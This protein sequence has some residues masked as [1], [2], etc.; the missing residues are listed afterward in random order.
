MLADWLFANV[1]ANAWVRLLAGL[2]ILLASG[3]LLGHIFER[4]LGQPSLVGEV[5]A[6]MLLAVLGFGSDASGIRSVVAPAV[7]NQISLLAN[8][9][10]LFFM[11]VVG[12]EFDLS[13]LT[14]KSR[15]ALVIS[16]VSIL[17]PLSLALL[18]SPWLY[19][20]YGA[21]EIRP[22]VFSSFLGL[23][24]SVTALPVLGRIMIGR[25]V[26]TSPL[27]RLVLLCA[28]ADDVSAWCLLA[29]V[30]GLSRG[31]FIESMATPGLTA[32][33]GLLM[34]TWV[35]RQASPARTAPSR[36]SPFTG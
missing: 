28:A 12:L 5:L 27:G 33:Y 36:R 7:V 10:V 31:R 6:G 26:Q 1:H 30:S 13:A 4:K 2:V 19:A 14:Q 23:A 18:I 16:Q 35:R 11:F 20:R 17:F 34:V 24:L 3:R 25:N 29:L 9:G 22:I 15:A 21:P 8:I 32:L